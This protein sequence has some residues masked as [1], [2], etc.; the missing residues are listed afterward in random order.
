VDA[1]DRKHALGCRAEVDNLIP[2]L[3]PSADFED[4]V[5]PGGARSLDQLR[6]WIGARV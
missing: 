6:R 2:R 4:A 5:D 1:E 3:W